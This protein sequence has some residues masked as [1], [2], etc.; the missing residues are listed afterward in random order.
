MLIICQWVE[1]EVEVDELADDDDDDETYQLILWKFQDKYVLP[2][3]YD[4]TQQ[5]IDEIV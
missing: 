4:E 3:E 5:K 1:V 2:Y